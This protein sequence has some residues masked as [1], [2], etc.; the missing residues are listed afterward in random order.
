[1]V[2]IGGGTDGTSVTKIFVSSMRPGGAVK[3]MAL[4]HACKP[5][6]LAETRD[7]HHISGFKKTRIDFLT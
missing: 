5:F 4:D 7:I 3:S 2:R 1:M 6:S